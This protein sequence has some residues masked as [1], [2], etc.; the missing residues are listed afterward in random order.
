MTKKQQTLGKNITDLKIATSTLTDD[1]KKFSNE[2][3]IEMMYSE[4]RSLENAIAYYE[5]L[6][7]R[8]RAAQLGLGDDFEIKPVTTN[9][10]GQ[11]QR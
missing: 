10:R 1:K 8:L 3:R 4:Q 2:I 9:S 6:Q 11:D 7:T 5:Q